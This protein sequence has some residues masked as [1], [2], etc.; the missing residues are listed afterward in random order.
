[1]KMFTDKKRRRENSYGMLLKHNFLAVRIKFDNFYFRTISS[2]KEEITE[3]ISSLG[4]ILIF[5]NAKRIFL[6]CYTV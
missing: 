6:S 5:L 4:H 3:K 2:K 1:M